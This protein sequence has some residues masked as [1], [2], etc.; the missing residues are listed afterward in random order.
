MTRISRLTKLYRLLR[1]VKLVKLIRIIKVK[2]KLINHA[3]DALKLSKGT[4][5]LIYLL[6]TFFV[7]QHL[8]CCLW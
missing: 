3:A 1:L 2:N 7:M 8:S 6:I 4:E 5:R